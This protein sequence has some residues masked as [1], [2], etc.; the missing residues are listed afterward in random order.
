MLE[1]YLINFCSPTLAG[2]KAG[3]LFN[4]S[5]ID[6]Q[7]LKRDVARLRSSLR[8][9]GLHIRLFPRPKGFQLF[10][11]YREKALFPELQHPIAK[12]MLH[13]TGY[14]FSTVDDALDR[15]G[16]RLSHSEAFPHEI[17][18]FLSYPPNDVKDFIRYGAK[19]CCLTGHWCV[20]SEKEKAAAC[21]AQFDHCKHCYKQR[22]AQHP[23]IRPLLVAS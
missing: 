16:Q 7:D 8:D 4:T 5:S 15:L 10:Y 3:S 19:A 1:T 17:G 20:F 12:E 6:Q 23:D 2:L 18:L 11:L 9:A 13:A 22:F 21:F 14:F